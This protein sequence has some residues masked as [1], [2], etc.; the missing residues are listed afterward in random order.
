MAHDTIYS[1]TCPST[2]AANDKL[3]ATRGGART[4]NIPWVWHL[5]LCSFTPSSAVYLSP[6]GWAPTATEGKFG[7]PKLH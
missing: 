2:P 4:V 6:G 3:A 1:P 7:I 5:H